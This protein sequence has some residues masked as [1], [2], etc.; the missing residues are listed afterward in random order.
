MIDFTVAIR[1]YNGETRL[2]ALLDSLK[3]QKNLEAIRWEVV[4][5]DNNSQD[6]TAQVIQS[7]ERDWPEG[8]PLRYFFEPRQGAAIAR[9][10]ALE[11]S[12]GE[13]VGFLDDDN[14]PAS[15]WVYTAYQFGQTHAKVGAYGGRIHADFEIPPPK[16]FHRIALYLAIVDHGDAAFC[17]DRHPQRLLPPGA[18]I[19]IKRSAWLESVPKTLRLLGPT[20][21]NLKSKG[22]D[23]ELFSYLQQ[24]GWEIWYNP[25]MQCF[26]KIPAWRLERNYLLSMAWGIGL[27]RHHLRMIRLKPI[28]RP[29]LFFLYWLNDFR[30]LSSA[31][32][33]KYRILKEDIPSAFEVTLLASICLS[34]IQSVLHF[35]S[36]R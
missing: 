24:G 5:V 13:W 34:P 4:I 6:Q 30:K 22:E 11:E 23:I 15:D 7:Y 8:F 3:V 12:Q 14:I 35:F 27:S 31:F 2:P 32:I 25:A 10:R 16:N 36:R 19:V 1:T 29:F 20:A 26:H 17:Y 18:S 21:Q 33:Q 9:K 28:Q